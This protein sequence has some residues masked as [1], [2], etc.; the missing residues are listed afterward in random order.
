MKK[1][2]PCLIVLSVTLFCQ[3]G[4][5]ADLALPN[6]FSPAAPAGTLSGSVPAKPPA[7]LQLASVAEGLQLSGNA[8]AAERPDAGAAKS[9]DGLP[10]TPIAL[11]CLAL[12]ICILVRRRTGDE[13]I[14]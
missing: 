11:A 8:R 6:A 2:L 1:L 4:G 13:L 9:T 7:Q 3:P 14:D 12:I 10:S 5:A